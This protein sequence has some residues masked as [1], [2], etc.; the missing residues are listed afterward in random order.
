MRKK[1]R[2][3]TFGA[4][5]SLESYGRPFLQWGWELR[6]LWR[7][8]L[9][10]WG[11]QSREG[12]L[13]IG[14]PFPYF[15]AAKRPMS[16]HRSS[17]WVADLAQLLISENRPTTSRWG[18]LTNLAESITMGFI[19][20]H[21]FCKVCLQFCRFQTLWSWIRIIKAKFTVI[22]LPDCGKLW[23]RRW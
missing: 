11:M 1:W 19:L 9:I 10:N 21:I 7:E 14:R 12:S 17:M 18:H 22:H 2:Q 8:P 13:W 15:T 5:T 20:L 6:P 3:T 4:A 16:R 23:R